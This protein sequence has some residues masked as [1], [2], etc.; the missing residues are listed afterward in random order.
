MK[1]STTQTDV[2][3]CLDLGDKR[4]QAVVLDAGGEEIEER[5]VATT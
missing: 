4:S 1:G 2:T 5:S 3:L